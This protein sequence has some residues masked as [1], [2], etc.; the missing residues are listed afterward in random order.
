VSEK[1]QQKAE[2]AIERHDLAAL[3]SLLEKHPTIVSSFVLDD[4]EGLLHYAAWQG[5]A[6]AIPLL[7]QYGANV[8]AQDEKGWTP[9]HY[10]AYHGKVD[11]AIALVDHGADVN[12]QTLSGH[13][14]LAFSHGYPVGEMLVN[15]GASIDWVVAARMGR[16]DII[17]QQLREE[18]EIPLRQLLSTAIQ[19][20]Q[21]SVVQLALEA[22]VNP[23]EINASGLAPLHES[24]MA[25]YFDPRITSLL[26]EHGA[27]SKLQA[28]PPSQYARATAVDIAIFFSNAACAA[29]LRA[30]E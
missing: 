15:R 24:V 18:Q 26:L 22:G 10:A 29:V 3:R 11:A 4:G 19:A 27:N 30:S 6:K 14:P 8:N 16:A 9:L 21:L 23:N 25:S 12:L 5:F 17:R 1:I 2:R 7:I 28:Q 13:S 20:Q